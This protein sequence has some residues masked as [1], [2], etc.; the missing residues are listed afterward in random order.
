MTRRRSEGP[1]ARRIDWTARALADLDA[2][3]AYIERDDEDAAQRWVLRLI[4]AAEKVATLPASGRR[5]P[6]F[7]RDDLRE[8]IVGA[9]RII[10]WIHDE[11]VEIVTIF[12]GH[13]R[14][15]LPARVR[16]P[17]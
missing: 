7:G 4:E 3:A 6:E 15:R 12:E 5:V 16:D 8:V 10:Y 2:I 9:Y 1:V 11:H 14:L 17:G 13:K